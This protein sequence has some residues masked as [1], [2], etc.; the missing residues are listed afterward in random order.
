MMLVGMYGLVISRVFT[1]GQKVVIYRIFDLIFHKI[2]GYFFVRSIIFSHQ[3]FRVGLPR[4]SAPAR[5]PIRSSGIVRLPP[6]NYRQAVGC[7]TTAK[8]TN[9]N[10]L[11][12]L[13]RS[14]STSLRPADAK[15]WPP[16]TFI[17]PSLG[18][19]YCSRV[20]TVL[21][22]LTYLSPVERSRLE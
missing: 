19:G 22:Y 2:F 4:Q 8:L 9:I 20:L 17:G 7:E 16:L 14:L 5:S 3:I 15:R 13:N 12:F 11:C 18:S 21:H 10:P 1:V 6:S